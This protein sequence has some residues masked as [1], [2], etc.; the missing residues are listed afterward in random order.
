VDTVT[1]SDRLV[2][3]ASSDVARSQAVVVASGFRVIPIEPGGLGSWSILAV[4]ARMVL[5]V[6][7]VR[8]WPKDLGKFGHPHNFPLTTVRLLH[9]WSGDEPLP[10]VQHVS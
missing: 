2:T 6:A 7:V 10:A 4:H 8:E 9:R 3:D 1:P 5:L